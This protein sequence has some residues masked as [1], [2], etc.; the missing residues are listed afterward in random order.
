[1][2]ESPRERRDMQRLALEPPIAARYGALP[3]RILDLAMAGARVEYTDSIPP[4]GESTLSFD[5]PRGAI[6]L[7]ASVTHRSGNL[8]GLTFAG[9]PDQKLVRLLYTLVT[10]AIERVRR[11][12]GAAPGPAFDPEQTGMRIPTP[13]NS[14]KL[15]DGIWRKRG[16]FMAIQPLTGFTLP[17]TE[18]PEEISRLSGDYERAGEDGRQLIRLFAELRVCESQ[19][20]HN[21]GNPHP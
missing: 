1:M 19:R 15:E 8:A 11:E 6:V 12:V 9:P 21:G 13:Y 18:D 7:Q 14:Y 10:A 5:S 3:V 2:M 17:V 4:T 20:P 16:A